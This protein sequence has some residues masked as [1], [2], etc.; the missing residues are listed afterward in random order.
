METNKELPYIEY[1]NEEETKK[2][3]SV[4]EGEKLGWVSVGKKKC[5]VPAK[6]VKQR[7][8]YYNF[9]AKQDDTWIVTYPR[10]GNIKIIINLIEVSN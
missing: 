6:Y 10:S 2:M 1:L 3:M 7:S 8:V 4:F 9:E 5:F